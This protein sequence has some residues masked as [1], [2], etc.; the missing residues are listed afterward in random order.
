MAAVPPYKRTDGAR[1]ILSRC[2][3]KDLKYLHDVVLF[4]GVTVSSDEKAKTDEQDR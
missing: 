4:E 3:Q 2:T 1:F